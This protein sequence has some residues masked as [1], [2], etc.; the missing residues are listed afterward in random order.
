MDI[1]NNKIF[2]NPY[3]CN[4]CQFQH[5]SCQNQVPKVYGEE[6]INDCKC[7]TVSHNLNL[8]TALYYSIMKR[9]EEDTFLIW[10]YWGYRCGSRVKSH[11]FGHSCT[12]SYL[13]TDIW[14]INFL[15][16]CDWAQWFWFP[17]WIA[18]YWHFHGMM[19]QTTA[20]AMTRRIHTETRIS[21]SHCKIL[22]TC[23]NLIYNG[24]FPNLYVKDT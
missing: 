12:W 14:T 21:R 10:N 11:F 5:T 1:P 20:F 15:V 4:T 3:R 16:V 8:S 23:T 22:C 7:N 17:K 13:Q 2:I 18:K 24:F 19:R 6:L 9:N